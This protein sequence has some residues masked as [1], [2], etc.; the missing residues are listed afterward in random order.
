MSQNKTIVPDVNYDSPQNPAEDWSFYDS[1]YTR[2][3]SADDNKRTVVGDSPSAMPA[4][5][6]IPGGS[7][8][9]GSAAPAAGGRTLAFQERVV[10]GVLYSVSKTLLGEIFPIYLGRNI[11]GSAPHCDVRLQ[12]TTVS[13]EHAIMQ[14]DRKPDTPGGYAVTINDYSSRYG[15]YAQ[16]RDGRYETL[17]VADN[18]IITVGTRYQLLLKLFSAKGFEFR[19]CEEFESTETQATEGYAQAPEADIYAPTRGTDNGRTVIY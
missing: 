5:G 2:D 8:P 9:V 4:G 3:T 11:V 6:T 10:V 1:L 16:G 12:E 15:T 17:T 13:P 19:E 14:I 18:S 7:A